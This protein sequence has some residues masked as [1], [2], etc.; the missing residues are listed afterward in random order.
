MLLQFLEMARVCG[1][2]KMEEYNANDM[3]LLYI[4][5][6]C[7]VVTEFVNEQ[8]KFLYGICLGMCSRKIIS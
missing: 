8:L 3:S 1:R 4:I 6:S 2:R 5:I 7:N